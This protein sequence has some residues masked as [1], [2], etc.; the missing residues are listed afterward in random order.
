MC[1]IQNWEGSQACKRRVRRHRFASVLG[2]ARDF[3]LMD[4]ERELLV[5]DNGDFEWSRFILI[6]TLIRTGIYVFLLGSAFTIFYNLPPNVVVA[7]LHMSLAS[8]ESCFQ[9][10]S[11]QEC[12]VLLSS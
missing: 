12:R 6:E 10:Y 3:G 7:E 4:V 8:P 11:Y 2:V 5:D 1:L 9:A